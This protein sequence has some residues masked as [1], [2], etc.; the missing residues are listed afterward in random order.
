MKFRPL[1]VVIAL[2]VALIFCCALKLE[3][4]LDSKLEG[5]ANQQP[6]SAPMIGGTSGQSGSISEN[7]LIQNMANTTI[8]TSSSSMPSSPSSIA[9]FNSGSSSNTAPMQPSYSQLVYGPNGEEILA[10]PQNTVFGIP[11]NQI[12]SG[13]ENLYILKSEIVPPVCPACPSGSVCPREKPCPPCPP[14]ARCPEPA[15]ECK[16]VPNFSTSRD[17]FPMPILNDFSTFAM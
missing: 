14:C 15:F 13:Q 12:P 2:V 11:G 8:A 3:C 9:A 17:A 10:N 7:Q 1:H 16:K 4:C 6:Y 5:L